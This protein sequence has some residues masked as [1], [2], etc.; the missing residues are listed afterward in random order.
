MMTVMEFS[1]GKAQTPLVQLSI[2][3]CQGPLWS[4]PPGAGRLLLI[5]W[6]ALVASG[7]FP[8][9]GAEVFLWIPAGV[10][11]CALELSALTALR[12]A[13]CGLSLT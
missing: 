11:V 1:S 9:M 5:G 13:V 8:V 12:C 6:A 2:V 4:G 7:Q 10:R 3:A